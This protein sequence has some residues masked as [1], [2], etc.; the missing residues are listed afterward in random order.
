MIVFGKLSLL[1]DLHKLYYNHFNSKL[2][3]NTNPLKENILFPFLLKIILFYIFNNKKKISIRIG[4][5]LLILLFFSYIIIIYYYQ[6]IFYLCLT[7]L[8]INL[9]QYVYSIKNIV[10]IF[11]INYYVLHIYIIADSFRNLEQRLNYLFILQ[12]TYQ[13][14]T[15]Q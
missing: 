12:M 4:H 11:N 7:N 5:Y 8:F 1:I 13:Y 14:S 3:S 9:L 10:L 2:F 6:Y 15:L